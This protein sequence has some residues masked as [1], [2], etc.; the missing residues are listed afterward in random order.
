MSHGKT[1]TITDANFETEVLQSSEPI[2][3]DFWATWCGPCRAIAPVLEEV[4]TEQAGVLKIGKMDVD[5]NQIVPGQFGV[6]SIPTL[7]LFVG[8]KEAT[9]IVGSMTK[10]KLMAKL[11][12]HMPAMAV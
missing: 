9:R 8:G 11:M 7:I 1:L 3:V 2:L 12:P 6:H 4:A 10:D 5:P